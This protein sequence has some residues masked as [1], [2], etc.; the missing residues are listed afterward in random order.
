MDTHGTRLLVWYARV[1][2]VP[3]RCMLS[4]HATNSWVH[5][6]LLAWWHPIVPSCHVRK[7][8][9]KQSSGSV[10]VSKVY[11]PG[12]HFWA[13]SGNCYLELECVA[14]CCIAG[15]CYTNP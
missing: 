8:A 14:N 10:V 6:Y 7:T 9:L 1:P 3:V 12:I 11:V 5:G 15:A 2:D 4:E 13:D